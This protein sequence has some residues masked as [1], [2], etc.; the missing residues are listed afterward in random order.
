MT[1]KI[2]TKYLFLL[3]IYVVVIKFIEIYGLGLY[4]TFADNPKL[5]PTT[6]Q[7]FQAYV[8]ILQFGLKLIVVILMCVDVKAP[9]RIDW[10]I[11]SISFFSL[12]IGIVLFIAWTL[13]KETMRREETLKL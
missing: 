6:V 11:M 8:A 9:K 10:L 4:F 13:Y 2:V 3:L 12:D 5:A 7:E 1:K